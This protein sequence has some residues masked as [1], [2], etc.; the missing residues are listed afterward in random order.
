MK[1]F[2]VRKTLLFVV[3]II[4]SVCVGFFIQHSRTQY[5]SF[6]V[7]KTSMGQASSER[8]PSEKPEES[9]LIN[10]NTDSPDELEK[11]DGIGEKTAERIIKYRKKNGDF[12]VIE[13][14]MRVSGIGK[15]KF[16]AIKDFICAE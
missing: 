15:K 1:K 7:Q 13:D 11:L 12:E 16:E 5:R 6:F 14:I 4:A 9:K 3:L 10:I 2:S 8:K